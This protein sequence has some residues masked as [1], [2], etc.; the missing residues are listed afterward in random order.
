MGPCSIRVSQWWAKEKHGDNFCDQILRGKQLLD[1]S[2][3]TEEF[4]TP[5]AHQLTGRSLQ[6]VLVSQEPPLT[7]ISRPELLFVA[8]P[9]A[10]ASAELRLQAPAECY[11]VLLSAKWP[12]PWGICW[13]TEVQGS[14]GRPV[15]EST[16]AVTSRWS[17]HT[18]FIHTVPQSHDLAICQGLLAGI[19]PGSCPLFL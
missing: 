18:D 9:G 13:G 6:S 4:R 12:R 17:L 10:L 11:P 3:P 14:P 5:H 15:T 19:E 2:S 8:L 7:S 1:I 16:A